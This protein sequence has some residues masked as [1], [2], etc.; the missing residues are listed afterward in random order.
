[1]RFTPVACTIQVYLAQAR[2]SAAISTAGAVLSCAIAPHQTDRSLWSFSHALFNICCCSSHTGS[3]T[4][5][6]WQK[7][8]CLSCRHHKL[9]PC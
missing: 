5:L 2:I 4:L 1:M 8:T 6:C 9:L 3:L 7:S